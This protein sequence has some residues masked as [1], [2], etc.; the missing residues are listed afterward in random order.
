MGA[1]P[2]VFQRPYKFH[3]GPL[4]RLAVVALE[5]P[6]EPLAAEDPPLSGRVVGRQ[7]DP[8]VTQPLMRTFFMIMISELGD[9]IT[10]V[11]FAKEDHLVGAFVLDG[12]DEAFGV[13][14][15]LLAQSDHLV[16]AFRLYELHEY[17]GEDSRTNCVHQSHE[18]IQ[19]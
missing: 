5:Q 1:I 10:Q 13:P 18:R 3:P 19:S 8:P 11:F 15:M 17:L 2:A 6:T 12:L 4:C 16:Q 14:N 9:H 7:H